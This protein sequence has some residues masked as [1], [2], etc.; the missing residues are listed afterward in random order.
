MSSSPHRIRTQGS[1]TKQYTWD[2][3]TLVPSLA[4]VNPGPPQ[5]SF[6][7]HTP[8]GVPLYRV[9]GSGAR[10]FYHFDES[11]NVA[12]LTNGA[13]SV[14]T[15]YAYQPTGQVTAL[16]LTAENPFT[17]AGASGALQEGS[18]GL[19][20]VGGAVYDATLMNMISGTALGRPPGPP[21]MPGANVMRPPGPPIMPG[22]NVMQP[23]GPPVM[24]GAN[25]MISPGPPQM[26]GANVM[27]PPGPPTMPNGFTFSGFYWMEPP[28][29]SDT[30]AWCEP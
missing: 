8:A 27:M 23:P 1:S 14:V 16:G 22:A 21:N 17:L 3:G 9:D 19:F 25:V 20:R 5:L 30:S 6:F 24:P 28:L 11:G 10:T 7:V 18:G 12:F 15:S 4:T 13:G 29:G 26:P 2:Y